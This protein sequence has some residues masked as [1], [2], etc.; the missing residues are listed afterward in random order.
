MKPRFS[1]QNDWGE[2]E[3]Q[4]IIQNIA[5]HPSN[6][7]WAIKAASGT[8]SQVFIDAVIVDRCSKMNS[9][10]KGFYFLLRNW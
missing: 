2:K 4:L 8:G 10:C 9:E 5:H 3:D 6:I 7:V 1:F